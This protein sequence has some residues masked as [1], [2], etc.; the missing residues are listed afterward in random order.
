MRQEDMGI[1]AFLMVDPT[2]R[3]TL[4]LHDLVDI[5]EIIHAQPLSSIPLVK[6]I[7]EQM[8]RSIS[9]SAHTDEKQQ[10]DGMA[11]QEFIAWTG[12]YQ[13]LLT[14]LLIARN[15][16]EHRVLGKK[17]WAAKKLRR[18]RNSHKSN[19]MYILKFQDKISEIRQRQALLSDFNNN[20]KQNH[21]V[22]T[23]NHTAKQTQRKDSNKQRESSVIKLLNYFSLTK[24]DE[25]TIQANHV[26]NIDAD[27]VKERTRGVHLSDSNFNARDTY[28]WRDEK[29]VIYYGNNKSNV[30]DNVDADVNVAATNVSVNIG[31]NTNTNTTMVDE[32]EELSSKRLRHKTKQ[33]PAPKFVSPT[34]STC[35]STTTTLSSSASISSTEEPTLLSRLSLSLSLSG[36]L[37]SR[38]RRSAMVVVQSSQ[39]VNNHENESNNNNNNDDDK[40]E[41]LS[42]KRESRGVKSKSFLEAMDIQRHPQS[43]SSRPQQFFLQETLYSTDSCVQSRTLQLDRR[44]FYLRVEF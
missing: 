15:N 39:D 27:K 41:R 22:K 37:I 42:R 35:T 3:R 11:L 19:V 34:T 26:N 6:D 5:F 36:S 21:K 40:G 23:K 43:H 44:K 14:P 10:G 32:A 33:L 4:G 17:F 24:N 2:G 29:R 13:F 1:F 12:K 20:N 30:I 28:D 16:I 38:H 8:V 18:A 7:V 9:A 31:T 25:D